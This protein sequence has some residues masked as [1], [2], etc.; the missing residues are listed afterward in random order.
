MEGILASRGWGLERGQWRGVPL[1]KV[2]GSSFSFCFRVTRVRE[3]LWGSQALKDGR[4]VEASCEGQWGAG[5]G[6]SFDFLLWILFS[7]G[8]QRGARPPR[9]SRAPRLARHQG[10]QGTKW[11]WKIPEKKPQVLRGGSGGG[12]REGMGLVGTS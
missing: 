9:N 7:S 4:L 8:T 5:L 3:G 1:L 2:L 6:T 10:R 12:G 11:G